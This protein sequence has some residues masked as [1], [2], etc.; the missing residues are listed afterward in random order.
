MLKNRQLNK[1]ILVLFL[2][3]MIIISGLGIFF[4]NSLNSLHEQIQ[5]GQVIDL[6]SLQNKTIAILVIAGILF[7]V[8][9]ITVVLFLS[10]YILYPINKLIQSPEKLTEEEKVTN[11]ML[12]T[13][14]R[15]ETQNL[16]NI[17]GIMTTRLNDFA[18]YDRWNH[19]F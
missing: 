15:G 16:E 11:R 1:V 4:L 19:S 6:Q 10:Q 9:G 2:I 7:A 14:N 18:S 12:K 5:V 17:F 13:K 3:G 8:V